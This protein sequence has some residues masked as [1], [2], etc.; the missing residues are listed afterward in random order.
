MNT[1]DILTEDIEGVNERLAALADLPELQDF[2]AAPAKRIRPT[3]ALLYLRAN[4]WEVD[5]RIY[6]FLSAIELI[7]NA[8]LIHD[9]IIDESPNRRGNPALHAALG[10]KLA[11]ISGDYLLS[12][13]MTEV[14]KL[15]SVELIALLAETMQKMCLGELSQQYNRFKALSVDEYLLKSEQKTASLFEAA[16]AGCLVIARNAVTK[17]SHNHHSDEIAALPLVARNDAGADNFARNF[18]IA[19]QIRNDLDS[20]QDIE[21]GIFN[22]AS[23]EL[24]EIY[25][26]KALDC[27]NCL[28]ENKYKSALI[29]LTERLKNERPA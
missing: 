3:L 28:E 7:H 15:D 11:V 16:V 14:S 1:L 2:L 25:V 21:N 23:A 5:E 27:L 9:D 29:E 18:G 24:L 8:S 22:C 13:A 12:K 17:Q 4:G 26:E 6:S 20:K 19:F 10:S